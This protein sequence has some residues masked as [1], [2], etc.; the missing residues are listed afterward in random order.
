[1]KSGGEGPGGAAPVASGCGVLEKAGVFLVSPRLALALLVAVLACCLAG[2]TAYRGA[3]AGQVIFSSLWF[4]ALLVLLAV[5]SATAFFSRIWRRKLTLISIGMV[6]FHVSFAALLG[7]IVYNRLFHFWGVLRLTEGETL[8][9]G[10]FTS[11]DETERGRF[12]DPS[13]LRG[14]TTLARMHANYVAGGG[15]KRAAYEIVVDAAEAREKAT[16]YPTEYLDFEGVRFFASKE[17]YSLLVVL[18]GKDGTETF[19]A[20]VP[21]QSLANE[22]G[23]FLYGSG[24]AKGL[25]YFVFPP[26]PEKPIAALQLTY[27]P[28]PAVERGGKVR[29]DLRPLDP[30]GKPGPNLSETVK[31][32][33]PFSAGGV[34]IS[35]KEVRYWAAMEVRYDPGL[36][37]ILSS[38]TLG[39]VGMVLTFVGRL[40]QGPRG[41]VA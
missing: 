11:Y 26:P 33:E 32:G 8:A 24:T 19:G 23:S 31:I 40:R 18:L 22:D 34:R 2:V 16:I 3:D 41:K 14:E 6:L 4:N 9:N 29:F 38:L 15:N 7:G 30:E 28:D 13:N 12:F 5:S 1:M 10:Q 17:G 35:V 21:L 27:L 36:R 37:V 39:L 20:F 25:A